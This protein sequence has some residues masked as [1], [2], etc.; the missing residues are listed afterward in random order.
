MTNQSC[1]FCKVINKEIPA[2]LIDENDDC[3]VIEDIAPKAPIHYLIIP[4]KHIVNLHDLQKSDLPLMGSMMFMAKQIAQKLPEPKA[5]GLIMNN[6][7]Q[8]GQSVMHMHSHF[9]SGAK[10]TDL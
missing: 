3:I 2:K 10:L 1:V 5:F 8:A 6:G 9:L 7:A 4:K